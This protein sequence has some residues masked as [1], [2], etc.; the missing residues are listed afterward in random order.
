MTECEFSVIK[1]V[2]D[3]VQF[4][5]VNIGI[6]LL[7]KQNKKIHSKYMTNFNGFFKRLGV[8][9]IHGLE[10]SFENYEPVLE[11]E[12]NDYLWQLHDSF[13]GSIFYSEPIKIHAKEID[14][15]LQKVFDK[16]ISIPDKKQ[17]LDEQVSVVK[18]KTRLKQHIEKLKFPEKSYGEKFEIDTISGIPQIRDFAFMNNDTL[19]NTIDIFDFSENNVFQSFKLFLYEIKALFKSEKYKK[20]KP[21]I[22]SATPQSNDK[23]SNIAKQ[24]IKHINMN[25]IPIIYPESQ[26]E[27]MQE[28]RTCIL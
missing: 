16:M 6:A 5:P 24:S 25:K 14:I 15:T 27:K 11:I 28:I 19:I 1:Y 18:I 3:I 26:E 2:P 22:F 13:H 7:D 9:K 17:I 10:R 20:N 21:L 12:S 4:E 8:E 23:L